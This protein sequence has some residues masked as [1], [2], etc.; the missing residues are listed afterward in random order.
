MFC[1]GGDLTSRFNF[2]IESGS[3]K[4]GAEIGNS[5]LAH[6]GFPS[7]INPGGQELLEAGEEGGTRAPFRGDGGGPEGLQVL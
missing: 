4:M 6:V 5:A 1:I 7:E 2:E 3:R